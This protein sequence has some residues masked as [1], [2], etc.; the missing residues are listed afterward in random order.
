MQESNILS[1]T[2]KFQKVLDSQNLG[3]KGL[4]LGG[5]R[6]GIIGT[7]VSVA[8]AIALV[9]QIYAVDSITQLDEGKTAA[10]VLVPDTATAQRRF[11]TATR[12]E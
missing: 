9:G 5:R 2:A 10:V 7:D 1:L 8:R 3:V 12:K 4:Y 11:D 6:M